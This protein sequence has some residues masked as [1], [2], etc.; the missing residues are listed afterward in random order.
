MVG[1]IELVGARI[2]HM[3]DIDFFKRFN[4]SCGHQLRDSCLKKGAGV[5][6]RLTSEHGYFSARYTV[7]KPQQHWQNNTILLDCRY[8]DGF[9]TGTS[10]KS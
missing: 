4:D 1:S 10:K 8:T 3:L 2:R 7:I 9:G 6:D 5:L